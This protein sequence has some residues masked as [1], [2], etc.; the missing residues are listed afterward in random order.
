MGGAETGG[1]RAGRP[2]PGNVAEG[3][4]PV[5]VV[6][7]GADTDGRFALLETRERPGD[8]PPLHA[9]TREDEVV[10]VLEGRVTVSVGGERRDCLTGAA[11]LLPRGRE[12]AFRVESG[13]ARLLV[14]L[15]PAGLEG[16]YREVGG[17]TGT[18]DMEWL[19]TISARYGVEITGPN[20]LA[21]SGGDGSVGAHRSRSG[22]DAAQPR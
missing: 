1:G 20:P 3:G 9:H 14:L 5:R 17:A 22:V 21:G 10:Y 18:H 11:V 8:E 13:E 19:V 6:V 2:D 16:L 7:S 4:G 12:H 15:L